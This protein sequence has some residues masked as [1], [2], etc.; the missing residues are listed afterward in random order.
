MKTVYLIL[1][2][3]F[4]VVP[5]APAL[6]ECNDNSKYL[7]VSSE[8]LKHSLGVNEAL[9]RGKFDRCNV[10]V[11]GRK[12]V[13]RKTFDIGLQV[14]T[15]VI[16]QSLNDFEKD[17]LS[18][19]LQGV[20]DIVIYNPEPAFN[21]TSQEEKESP[22]EYAIRFAKLARDN[23]L[24]SVA[25]PSCRLVKVRDAR[26]RFELCSDAIYKKIAPYYDFI[27]VQ[28]QSVQSDVKLYSW[29]VKYAANAIKS[30]CA[31]TK[32][33]AQISTVDAINGNSETMGKAAH[34]VRD[35]VDGYWVNVDNKSPDGKPDFMALIEGYDLR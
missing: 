9:V 32:V 6:A 30:T 16:Y 27:D 17:I 4:L 34:A 33:I 31:N 28:A 10:V 21:A 11:G 1:A 14:R 3:L 26:K 18:R 29:A 19:K 20:V 35:Y 15:R 7:F 23:G 8:T 2:Y 12:D 13:F 24:L 5:S 25:A 22:V